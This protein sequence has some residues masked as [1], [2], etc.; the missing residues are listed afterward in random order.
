MIID[1]KMLSIDQS[2][3]ATKAL[4]LRAVGQIV[5]RC[6]ETH[7][8]FYPQP[9]WVEHNPTEIWENTNTAIQRVLKQI[10]ICMKNIA[11]TGYS[12]EIQIGVI[13]NYANFL[14]YFFT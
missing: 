3:S 10:N 9:D 7:Q 2:T 12:K 8:Q 5:H 1:K 14:F 13:V 11:A 6:T 4:L